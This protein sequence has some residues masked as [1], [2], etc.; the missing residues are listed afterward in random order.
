M[1]EYH[2][3]C[4]PCLKATTVYTSISARRRTSPCE[5]CS[6][7]APFDLSAEDKHRRANQASQAPTPSRA[8]S[9]GWRDILCNDC[10]HEDINN[11][12]EPCEEC[13]S[14]DVTRK[15]MSMISRN[16]ERYPRYDRG[17]GMWLRSEQHRRDVC[18][19]TGLTPIEGEWDRT[20][21]YRK[22]DAADA[23]HDTVYDDY[24]HRLENAPAFESWRLA[25]AQGR[26]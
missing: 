11:L 8:L 3:W 20:A 5:H 23:G 22:K 6:S 17:L 14:E 21:E 15:P 1:P 4:E 24:V 2:Y 12:D 19:A 7:P 26:T 9:T 10:G 25:R 13:G 16:S 18:K